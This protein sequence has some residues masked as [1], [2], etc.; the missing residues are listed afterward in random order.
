MASKRGRAKSYKS[1]GFRIPLVFTATIAAAGNAALSLN[2]QMDFRGENI[3]IDPT[4]VGPSC[5]VT[6]PN[7]GT[8]PQIAG[9][10]TNNSAV[11]GTM[12]PPNQC[13]ALNFKMDIA[14]QGN[15]LSFTA[16]NTNTTLA[17][18]FAMLI[19]GHEVEEDTGTTSGVSPA[20]SF[21]G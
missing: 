18:N 17:L 5:T 15:A 11:P 12:F 7:V 8:I 6:L 21:A 3:V 20:G 2:P 10:T 16:T 9:Q 13:G 4:I 19:F 14:N 1:T